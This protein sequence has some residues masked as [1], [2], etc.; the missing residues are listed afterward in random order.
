MGRHW[1]AQP[2]AEEMGPFLPSATKHYRQIKVIHCTNKMN[3]D[4]NIPKIGYARTK[5]KKFIF[6]K[7]RHG[8]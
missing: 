8:S 3:F 7:I 1:K 6:N 4:L 2:R 5:W